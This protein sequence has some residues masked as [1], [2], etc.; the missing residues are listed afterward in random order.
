M[1]K[2]KKKKYNSAEEIKSLLKI[3]HKKW[4]GMGERK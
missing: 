3:Y 2:K 4:N 1:R